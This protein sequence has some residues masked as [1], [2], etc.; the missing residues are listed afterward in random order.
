MTSDERR[1]LFRA[2]QQSFTLRLLAGKL[3]C[4]S[5]SVFL[6]PDALF[7]GFLVGSAPPQFA[8]KSLTLHFL[9]Q[10]PQGLIDVVVPYV[11]AQFIS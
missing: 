1:F 4:S 7:R 2:W 10:D 9:F 5:Y 3:M 6:F 8:K 11:N